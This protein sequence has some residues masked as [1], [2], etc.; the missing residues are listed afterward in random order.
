MGRRSPRSNASPKV[1]MRL[2]VRATIAATF[3]MRV[4]ESQM[5]TSI[6]PSLG[7]GL[8]SHQMCV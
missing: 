4:W 5:R 1:A 7:C 6:V 3:S 2:C 8:M